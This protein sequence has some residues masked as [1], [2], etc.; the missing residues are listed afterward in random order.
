MKKDKLFNNLESVMEAE[1]LDPTQMDSLE[2][3]AKCEMGCKKACLRGGQNSA[4]RVIIQ[5]KY[6]CYDSEAREC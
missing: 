1:I 3:G 2:G 6:E 4:Q 5:N